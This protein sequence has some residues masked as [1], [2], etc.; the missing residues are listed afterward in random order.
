MWFGGG[1]GPFKATP[2]KRVGVKYVKKRSGEDSARARKRLILAPGAIHFVADVL[3]LLI[4]M[5]STW[6]RRGSRSSTGRVEH[7]Y[8][9]KST[10]KL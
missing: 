7:Q 5:G 8:A 3:W 2:D 1:V 6:L 10:G 9:R 4:H